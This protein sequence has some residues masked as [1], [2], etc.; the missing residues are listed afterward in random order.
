MSPVY[1]QKFCDKEGVIEPKEMDRICDR[2]KSML[3][4]LTEMQKG[5]TNVV[6]DIREAKGPK[7]NPD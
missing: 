1:S 6:R 5:E 7:R 2:L 4:E 3:Q